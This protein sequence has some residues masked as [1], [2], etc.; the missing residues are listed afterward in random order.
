MG[1]CVIYARVLIGSITTWMAC[2][3]NDAAFG[4][5]QYSWKLEVQGGGG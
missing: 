1:I 5:L 4:A 2:K 3:Y